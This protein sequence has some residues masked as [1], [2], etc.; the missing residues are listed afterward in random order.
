MDQYPKW[1]YGK[2]GAAQIVQ[3][4]EADK[5]LGDGWYESPVDA[6]AADEA[7]AAKAAAKAK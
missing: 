5:A 7:Q 4:E 1:K 6:K 2:D 3:D